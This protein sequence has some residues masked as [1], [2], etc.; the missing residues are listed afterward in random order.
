[1]NIKLLIIIS[2]VILLLTEINIEKI[3]DNTTD[4]LN[5][6]FSSLNIN[7]E[8]INYLG[9]IAEDIVEK[10]IV[11]FNK[12][13]NILDNLEIN[14]DLIIN[15]TQD[16]KNNLLSIKNK[17][18]N[19]FFYY[20]KNKFIGIDKYD[21]DMSNQEVKY[22][23]S[24][25]IPSGTIIAF[26]SFNPPQGWALCDGKNNTPN[27]TKRFLYGYGSKAKGSFGGQEK[28]T[29]KINEIPNHTHSLTINSKTPNHSHYIV[30]HN[31]SN[32]A[33]DCLFCRNTKTIGTGRTQENSARHTHECSV[34]NTGDNLPHNNMPP[35]YVLTYIIKL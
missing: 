7:F 30:N 8:K 28:V 22:L 32:M 23:I 5:S 21:Q 20:N 29:L 19:S 24:D 33:G 2:L 6:Y 15:E 34:N 10:N 11:I 16:T 1:M 17:N 35:Y 25:L 14:K 9:K 4:K 26:N 31:G 18:D 13:V 12:K 27:L 3:T